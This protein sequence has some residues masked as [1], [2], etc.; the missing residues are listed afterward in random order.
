MFK[1][2][3]CSLYSDMKVGKHAEE[4]ESYVK[5]GTTKVLSEKKSEPHTSRHLVESTNCDKGVNRR[6]KRIHLVT[7]PSDV[8]LHREGRVHEATFL[9]PQMSSDKICNGKTYKI[10]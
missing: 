10:I 4:S 3:N 8:W 1:M 7:K 2:P 9:D 6:Q 5:S